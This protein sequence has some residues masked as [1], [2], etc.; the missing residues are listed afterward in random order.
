ML[1]IKYDW[2]RERQ[3]AIWDSIISAT[4]MLGLCIGCLTGGKVMQ[5]GRRFSCMIA[6]VVG[7]TGTGIN[8]V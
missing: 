6:C 2:P 8:L 7:L 5:F 4:P 3:Q 1:H